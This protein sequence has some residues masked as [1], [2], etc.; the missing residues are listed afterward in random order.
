MWL[1][2]SASSNGH[3]RVRLHASCPDALRQLFPDGQPLANQS[4][5]EVVV[6]TR[7]DVPLIEFMEA[8]GRVL[9]FPDGQNGSFP[10]SDEW[11]LRGAPYIPDHPLSENNPPRAVLSNCSISTWPVP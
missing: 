1:V 8:G 9:L 7:L 3:Q 4:T 10:L 6:A 2:P 5:D 11:F